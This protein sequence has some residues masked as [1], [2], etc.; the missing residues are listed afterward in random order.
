[1]GFIPSR[2]GGILCLKSIIKWL[3]ASR[4][5]TYFDVQA[6]TFLASAENGS[7]LWIL[8]QIDRGWFF[9]S[10]ILASCKYSGITVRKKVNCGRASC[11][12]S[13]RIA[14]WSWLLRLCGFSSSQIG[15][16]TFFTS[17]FILCDV[18]QTSNAGRIIVY[19]SMV[20]FLRF[21][22]S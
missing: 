20:T 7:C 2:W 17:K 12:I 18:L 3:A 11:F 21:V 19:T 4:L 15:P 22:I 8:V 9:S 5:G 14:A 16:W 13:L 1:M 10:S 6:M